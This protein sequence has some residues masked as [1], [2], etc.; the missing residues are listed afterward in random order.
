MLLLRFTKAEDISEALA[1]IFFSCLMTNKKK[2]VGKKGSE[3]HVATST[4]FHPPLSSLSIPIWPLLSSFLH[5]FVYLC[6]D[7]L[8]F[9]FVVINALHVL[10]SV[11]T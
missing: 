9:I 1:F 8:R 7:F 5:L 3:Q 10:Q 6:R 11:T 4:P 2:I